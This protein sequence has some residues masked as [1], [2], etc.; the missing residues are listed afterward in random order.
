M[1]DGLMT[2]HYAGIGNAASYMV[3]SIPFLTSSVSVSS[4]SVT[5]IEF[6]TITKFVTI[7]NDG[8][9]PLK[10]GFSENGVLNGTNYTV[11]SSSESFSADFRVGSIFLET[12]TATSTCTIVAGLTRIKKEAGFNNWSGSSGVG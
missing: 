9:N 7:R 10:F 2:R 5:E 12:T 1:S 8:S 4:G 6:P 11:L 3:S